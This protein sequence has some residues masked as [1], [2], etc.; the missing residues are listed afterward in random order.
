MYT[1][2]VTAGSFLRGTQPPLLSVSYGFKN[3][4][5]SGNWTMDHNFLLKQFPSASQV[6][7]AITR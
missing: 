7:Y 3:W 5:R 6:L 1:C 2:C 4:L